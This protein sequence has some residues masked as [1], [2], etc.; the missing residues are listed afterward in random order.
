MK[1]QDLKILLALVFIVAA[2]L[3]AY[4]ARCQFIAE[5][6]NEN[7]GTSYNAADIMLGI[8]NTVRDFR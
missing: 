5:R 7:F 4:Y 3:W 1:M 6:Y 8:H 2:P